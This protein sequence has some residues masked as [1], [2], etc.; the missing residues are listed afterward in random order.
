MNHVII[1]SFSMLVTM[2]IACSAATRPTAAEPNQPQTIDSLMEVDY[3]RGYVRYQAAGETKWRKLVEGE[4]IPQRGRIAIGIGSALVVKVGNEKHTYVKG[5]IYELETGARSKYEPTADDPPGIRSMRLSKPAPTPKATPA[6]NTNPPSNP[7]PNP[8]PNPA[9]PFAVTVDKVVGTVSWRA[10]EHD[11]WRKLTVGSTLNEGAQIRTGL[12]SAIALSD[13]TGGRITIDRLGQFTLDRTAR[14]GYTKKESFGLNYGRPNYRGEAAG[15]GRDVAPSRTLAVRDGRDAD[16]S[17]IVRML[18]GAPLTT[19]TEKE[20]TGK[21][22]VKPPAPQKDAATGVVIEFIRGQVQWRSDE[23]QPWRE[24]RVGDT[25]PLNAEIRVGLRSVCKLK[26]GERSHTIDRLGTK[27]V[28]EII[29]DHAAKPGQLGLKYGR[30]EYALN[31]ETV[32]STVRVPSGTLSSWGMFMV[33]KNGRLV[34]ECRRITPTWRDRRRRFGHPPDAEVHEAT[35][36][37]PAAKFGFRRG[38]V[39][40]LPTDTTPSP[41]CASDEKPNAPGADEPQP[42]YQKPIRLFDEPNVRE[43]LKQIGYLRDDE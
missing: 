35:I 4:H 5:G 14:N 40:D 38:Y 20:N 29:Q 30:V 9:K 32:Q 16:F 43:L 37:A 23:N 34:A 41:N 8:A 7:A 28:K 6:Q 12:R 31:S 19:D 39:P 26:I 13:K 3:A 1:I 42:W 15:D 36:T 2:H 10:S 22:T 33:E 27:A 18:F 24:A 25:L 17:E 21:A 11:T